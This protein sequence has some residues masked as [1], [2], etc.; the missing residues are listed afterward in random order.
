MKYLSA[1]RTL[2]SARELRRR[3]G[4]RDLARTLFTR[5]LHTS[6]TPPARS[7]HTAN[8]PGKIK[9]AEIGAGVVHRACQ[10]SNEANGHGAFFAQQSTRLHNACTSLIAEF[11]T[12]IVKTQARLY[13]WLIQFC[14]HARD[15]PLSCL[16]H[17]FH[18][19]LMP[20][21]CHCLAVHWGNTT[22][23]R[24]VVQDKGGPI[25]L[26]RF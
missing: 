20:L 19:V 16:S 18:A 8:E 9:P 10:G 7:L 12:P 23:R 6:W 1:I 15:M 11:V 22:P 3:G 26:D 2:L 4:S 17:A 25:V 24:R 13:V 21:S 14:S 5:Q